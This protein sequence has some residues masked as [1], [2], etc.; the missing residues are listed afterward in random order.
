MAKILQ[1]YV[2]DR[3]NVKHVYKIKAGKYYY[4]DK[5]ISADDYNVALEWFNA[6]RKK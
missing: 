1:F 3:K 4:D 6:N 2:Y 5:E